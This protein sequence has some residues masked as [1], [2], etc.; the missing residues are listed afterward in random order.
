[1]SLKSLI[2]GHVP[3]EVREERDR[4]LREL[5]SKISDSIQAVRS[6]NRILETLSETI[7]LNRRDRKK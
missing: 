4:E 3:T 1:M 5:K 2:A 7:D 6:G